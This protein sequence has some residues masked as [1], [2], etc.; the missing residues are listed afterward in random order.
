MEKRKVDSN[1]PFKLYAHPHNGITDIFRDRKLTWFYCNDP[2]KQYRKSKARLLNG[3]WFW[4][5]IV[6]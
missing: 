5:E 2:W 3:F 1:W 6:K 4:V